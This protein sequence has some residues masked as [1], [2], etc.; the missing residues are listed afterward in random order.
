MM[1]KKAQSY[2]LNSKKEWEMDKQAIFNNAKILIGDGENVEYTRG[3][4]E[5]L[6]MCFPDEYGDAEEAAES[7]RKLLTEKE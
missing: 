1:K 6:A 2:T 4:C 3:I 7:Y 5:L